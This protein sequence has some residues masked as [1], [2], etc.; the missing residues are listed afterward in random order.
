MLTDKENQRLTQVGPGTPGGEL[1]R[2]YWQ[3]LCPT[4]E[5]SGKTR[6]KRI[7]ILAENCSCSAKT[8]ARSRASANNVRTAARR[9]TSVSSSLTAFAAAITA[10]NMIA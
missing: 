10:G 2:R 3:A 6:K 1:L 4:K 7:Q 9:C 5:L 8:T